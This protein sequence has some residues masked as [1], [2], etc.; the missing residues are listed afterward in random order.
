MCLGGALNFEFSNLPPPYLFECT[1]KEALP[2]A[3]VLLALKVVAGFVFVHFGGGG[4]G[5][6]G[7][8]AV[9]FK[10]EEA[11]QLQYRKKLYKV[12]HFGL[13]V[14]LIGRL[15]LLSTLLHRFSE[16]V[17]QQVH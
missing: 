5:G 9:E 16:P 13:V 12:Q 1:E 14:V 6:D 4:G 8:S 17:K 11:Y 2:L 3:A 10:I 7:S 15:S